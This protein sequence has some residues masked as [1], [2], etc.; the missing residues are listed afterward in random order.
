M[1][2]DINK[3]DM[4][5]I[6]INNLWKVQKVNERQKLNGRKAK[7]SIASP[8]HGLVA[9][10]LSKVFHKSCILLLG[11][12]Y[13]HPINPSKCFCHKN[14]FMRRFLILVSFTNDFLTWQVQ[15]VGSQAI[16]DSDI[17]SNESPARPEYRP[18]GKCAL[19]LKAQTQI[20]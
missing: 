3:F 13:I 2:I 6:D 10:L 11:N 8:R 15:P 1:S 20:F 9:S 16:V 19:L 5:I 4:S 17:I 12:H 18:A 14:T 7:P